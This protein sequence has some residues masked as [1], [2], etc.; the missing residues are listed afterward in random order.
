M[1]GHMG[2]GVNAN[3][4]EAVSAELMLTQA[5]VLARLDPDE[6]GD[7]PKYWEI[8][9]ELRRRGSACRS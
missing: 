5:A 2:D 3:T 8:I 9:H 6:D 4:F 7:E 1:V